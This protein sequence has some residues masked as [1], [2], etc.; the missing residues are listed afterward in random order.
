M[1]GCDQYTVK[2]LFDQHGCTCGALIRV[3]A[4]YGKTLTSEPL[5]GARA[6][7]RTHSRDAGL[8]Y[9]HMYP[10]TCTRDRKIELRGLLLYL[11][12]VCDTLILM[13]IQTFF[14]IESMKAPAVPTRSDLGSYTFRAGSVADHSGRARGTWHAPSDRT[15]RTHGWSR[16]A[17]NLCCV[18]FCKSLEPCLEKDPI[19]ME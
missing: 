7:A 18:A 14:P 9:S 3:H 6:H 16:T 4:T 2:C 11:C 13:I 15:G 8:G 5:I 12:T 10:D 19:S 17:G 1:N